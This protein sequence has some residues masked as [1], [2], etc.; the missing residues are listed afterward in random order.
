MKPKEFRSYTS[1]NID[2]MNLFV[3][4]G[5][6]FAML[7]QENGSYPDKG[8]AQHP[9]SY[10]FINGLWYNGKSFVSKDVY[11]NNG[12]FVSKLTRVDTTIDLTG[13]Y[14]VPPFSEAHTHLLEGIGDYASNIQRYINHGVFYVKNPNNI[15][16]WTEKIYAK[17]N[18]PHSID[19]TFANGG[20]TSTGGHPEIL[21][22]ERL[23]LH[24]GSLMDNNE[25]GWF[26]N[27]SYFNVDS[28]A[29][30]NEQWPLILAG[31]P[32]FIKVYLANSD[33]LG[34]TPPTSRFP[35]RKG[36]DPA[37]VP[38]V[39][40]KAHAQSLR[41][42]AHVE[43]RIDFI[44]AVNAG[45]DEISHTPGFYLFSKDH[46]DRYK[47]TDADAKTAARRGIIVVTALL[48]KNLT[49][50]QSLMSLVA[51]TQAFN[52][53]LLNRNGVKVAIGSDHAISPVDE[54]KALRELNVFD[55][56]TILKMWCETS[57]LT[58]FPDRRIAT[59]SE[60]YESSFL[61]LEGNPLDDLDF[62]DKIFLRF[63]Q[64]HILTAGHVTSNSGH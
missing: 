26:K 54:V 62:T 17:I 29:E 48:S 50:D 28:E 4:S 47:L 21:Y 57:A 59:L 38:L 5:L 23:R 27:K 22:E 24:L 10:K 36:L 7:F 40:R 43:T 2:H 12:F 51:E 20:L 18:N 45:V 37:L 9:V 60:G 46:V 44:N 13:K 41:V 14:I 42:T 8:E 30:L 25:R 39:V 55:N 16:P 15:K 33:D 3:V 64:G 52:L 19:A 11:V 63:K 58:I 53:A 56:A 61:A 31:N 35:L 34:K 1:E 6:C 32:G 49:E